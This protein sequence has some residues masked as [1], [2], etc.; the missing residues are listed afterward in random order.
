MD[1][2]KVKGIPGPMIPKESNRGAKAVPVAWEVLDGEH[3]GVLR[4]CYLVVSLPLTDLDK[5]KTIV[6]LHGSRLSSRLY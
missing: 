2:N 6:Y 5:I 1:D 3:K 4:R